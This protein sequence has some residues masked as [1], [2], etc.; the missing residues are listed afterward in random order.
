[1][2]KWVNRMWMCRT[3]EWSV[4][5]RR[6]MPVPASRTST[7]PSG[8][9]TPTQEV[10]PPYRAV[11]GPGVASDPRVPQSVTSM[12]DFPE[13]AHRAEEDVFLADER[14]CRDAQMPP[15]AVRALDPY[16][17]AQ[18]S[19]LREHAH[20]RSIF[21]RNGLALVVQSGQARSPLSGGNLSGLVKALMED[22]FCRLVVEDQR[23]HGVD[24]QDGRGHAARELPRQNDLDRFRGR[25]ASLPSPPGIQ[26]TR[27]ARFLR[28][29]SS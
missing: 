10:L 8:P 1:M 18:R 19:A 16:R 3:D 22:R 24:K 9:R 23:A 14:E 2:C 11:S 28:A 29:V 13:D 27:A 7:V 21:R 15:L 20:H 17:L 25:H 6:R 12:S 26:P 4:V 5:P